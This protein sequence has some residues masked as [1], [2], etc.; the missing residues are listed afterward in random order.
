MAKNEVDKELI[1]IAPLVKGMTRGAFP[2]DDEFKNLVS[3]INTRALLAQRERKSRTYMALY[4]DK[5]IA[6]I[7]ISMSSITDIQGSKGKTAYDFPV[8]LVGKLYTHP[9]FRGNGVGKELMDFVLDITQKIDALTGCVGLLVD[10]NNNDGTVRFYENFGFVKIDENDE[11]RT[12]KMF[13][14]IPEEPIIS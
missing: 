3:W 8:L 2:N 13:F 1:L 11:D 7:T 5:A 6:Y 12:V 9:D 10:A 14:K 4:D